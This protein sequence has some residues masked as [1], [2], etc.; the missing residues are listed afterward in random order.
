MSQT[1]EKF[2]Y[3]PIPCAA[4]DVDRLEAWLEDM[5]LEGL[6]LSRDGFMTGFGIFYRSNPRRVS[7][8]LIPTK[9]PTSL[10]W[11][12]TNGDPTLQEQADRERYGWDYLA[13][14]GDFHIYRS[15]SPY[16]SDLPTD[17]ET[18]EEALK[19]L[20]KRYR[21]SVFSGILAG[22]VVSSVLKGEFFRSALFLGT[23]FSLLTL[24]LLVSFLFSSVTYAVH[25]SRL[26]RR[27][28]EDDRFRRE[29]V[30]WRSRAPGHYLFVL[31]QVVGITAAVCMI[32]SVWAASTEPGFRT[33][34]A[35]Y[36]GDPPF[37]TAA[38]LAGEGN[39]YLR[40]QIRLGDSNTY[41]VW[42][43]PIARYCAEW[44][45]SGDIH[46]GSL[47]APGDYISLSVEYFDTAAPWLARAV[48]WEFRWSDR[49]LNN[50]YE[51]LEIPS[52]EELGVDYAV[53]YAK[54]G[55]RFPTVILQKG[56]Q[57]YHAYFVWNDG[58]DLQDTARAMAAA[59]K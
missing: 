35:D 26:R 48:T 5:A 20:S 16:A 6:F 37:A 38:D 54:R 53:A 52:A 10:L 25:Y 41:R 36:P 17:R 42:N 21:S 1:E 44:D 8:R 14:Y 23:W 47:N 28:R 19:V 40:E 30:D 11:D 7:Y 34:V 33:P 27:I 50:R 32:L 46:R 56:T 9:K 57:V 59:L 2:Y 24:A 58:L 31:G 12:E 3:R 43:D 49:F 51:E 18:R 29:D 4:C 39:Y 45:E 22:S 15:D 55:I 13:R